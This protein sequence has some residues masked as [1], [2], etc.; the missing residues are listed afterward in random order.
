MDGKR[1]ELRLIEN[2]NKFGNWRVVRQRVGM[3]RERELAGL[4]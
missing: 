4:R 1:S 3:S 2:C